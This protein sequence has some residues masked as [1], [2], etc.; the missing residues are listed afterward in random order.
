M[1]GCR[2]CYLNPQSRTLP[3]GVR[4]VV[5]GGG[6]DIDPEHYGATGDAGVT[7][8]PARDQLEMSV[9]KAALANGLPLMGICRGAQ[10]INVVK[11]GSLHID[12]RPLRHLTPNRN[13][14]FRVKSVE[15]VADS[16]LANHLETKAIRVNSL[17]S[18]AID[19]VGEALRVVA[20][21]RD[22]FIQAVES[23]NGPFVLGTQWHPEY[24]PYRHHHR[25]VFSLFIN[26]VRQSSVELDH[27]ELIPDA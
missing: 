6:D 20:R 23:E 19:V 5:I 9:I 4:G 15:L 16:R 24:L 18:Q 14:V 7:Y 1:L 2:A 21:D 25:S 8:D 27:T 17:H 11:G 12:I 10:L 26:Q 13:S 22:G 3:I